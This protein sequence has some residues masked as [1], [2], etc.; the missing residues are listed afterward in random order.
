MHLTLAQSFPLVSTLVAGWLMVKIAVAKGA[1]KVKQAD[2]CAAC[3]T[4][5]D[6]GQCR[7][8]TGK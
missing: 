6:R 1:V 7:C 8:T 4:R 3:G 2:R 5:R